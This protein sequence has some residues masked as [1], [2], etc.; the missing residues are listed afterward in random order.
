MLKEKKQQKFYIARHGE[1]TFNVDP[2]VAFT[3]EEPT[4][5]L[6]DR[7]IAEA[8]LLAGDLRDLLEDAEA[9]DVA[10]FSSPYVRTLATAELIKAVVFTSVGKR[11]SIVQD[12]RIAEHN[13]ACYGKDPD[14]FEAE[15]TA[16]KLNPLQWKFLQG[17]GAHDVSKRVKYF[18]RQNRDH[19]RFAAHNII[20][21][22]HLT[23]RHITTQLMGGGIEDF[24]RPDLPDLR[25]GGYMEVTI[26]V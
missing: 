24:M 15:A 13:W 7:G 11:V 5:S 21:T 22:H 10:I 8:Y 19:K 18:L 9:E 1:C 20:V 3:H 25:T 14:K 26:N 2:N 23:A 17:E 12:A 4:W 6:T 16:Y